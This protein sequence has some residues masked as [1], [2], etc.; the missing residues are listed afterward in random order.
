MQ[1]HARVLARAVVPQRGERLTVAEQPLRCLDVE[2]RMRA[3]L[4]DVAAQASL[5]EHGLDRAHVPVLSRVA[6]GH[7]RER[8][9]G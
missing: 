3:A 7:D 6:R 5:A 1:R 2:G 9:G 4:E 8:L